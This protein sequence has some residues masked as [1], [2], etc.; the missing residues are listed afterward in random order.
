MQGPEIKRFTVCH[1]IYSLVCPVSYFPVKS[2]H[3]CCC[4]SVW[5]PAPAHPPVSTALC[6]FPLKA[7]TRPCVTQVRASPFV[8]VAICYV[9]SRPH[10]VNVN[11]EGVFF[12]GLL[13]YLCDSFV[14]ADL[15]KR[16]RFLKGKALPCCTLCGSALPG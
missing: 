16:F 14:G 3:H 15:L 13:L 11:C 12:S 1:Q 5:L 4:W 6:S 9:S 10:S 2:A 8:Q 7:L